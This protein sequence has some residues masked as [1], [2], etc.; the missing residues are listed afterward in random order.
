MVP[1]RVVAI[2]SNIAF[3]TYAWFDGL[4][5]ILVLHGALLPQPAVV[6]S[7]SKARAQCRTRGRG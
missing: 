7:A 3:I 5:P 6:A 1:L 4:M 2:A